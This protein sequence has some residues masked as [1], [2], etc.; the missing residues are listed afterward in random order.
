M[1][2]QHR[3]MRLACLFLIVALSGCMRWQ[4]TQIEPQTLVATHHPT[5]VRVTRTD[6]TEIVMRWP[7]IRADTL[8]GL[9][10]GAPK[11]DTLAIALADI[12]HVAVEQSDILKSLGLSILVLALAGGTI[13]LIALSSYTGD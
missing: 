3:M 4:V 12:S 5:S 10:K 13:I 1:N 2:W 6:G 11:G 9:P 7:S 8:Y